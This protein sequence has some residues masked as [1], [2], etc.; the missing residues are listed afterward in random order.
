MSP[1]TRSNGFGR[2]LQLVAGAFLKR[3]QGLAL[4][5][6]WRSPV[7]LLAIVVPCVALW[8]MFKPV[9]PALHSLDTPAT[10]VAEAKDAP[11]EA[12]GLDFMKL[13]FVP[14]KDPVDT[15][16][17]QPRYAAQAPAAIK[18]YDGRKVRIRGFLMPMKMEGNEVR[19]FLI[20]AS[21]MSCCYGT[22]PRFWEFIAAKAVGEPVPNMMDRPLTFEGTLHVGDVYENGYWTQFYTMECSAVGK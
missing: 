9:A 10:G 8:M 15:K 22:T 21:Q 19:E 6:L 11:N 5:L 2:R 3:T 1:Q 13:S 17:G 4:F 18:A 14:E 20:V 16:T 12:V 7:V